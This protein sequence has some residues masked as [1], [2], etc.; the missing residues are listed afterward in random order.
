MSSLLSLWLRGT[1]GASEDTVALVAGEC[2]SSSHFDI[3]AN[4]LAPAFD[5]ANGGKLA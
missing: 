5:P 3:L 1:E 2:R 4:G